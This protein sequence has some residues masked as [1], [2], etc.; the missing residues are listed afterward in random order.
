MRD[1]SLRALTWMLFVGLGCGPVHA[2]S[3]L[4]APSGLHCN[5]AVEPLAIEDATPRL[6][7]SLTA[8]DPEMRGIEQ[9]AY[10]VLVS[11]SQQ[12]L[13]AHQGDIWDSGRIASGDSF[14]VVY[15]G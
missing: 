9:S 4:L 13:G 14:G 10:R 1:F 3:Q 12:A 2:Q 8:A 7:W 5:A 11:S 6:E 15:R